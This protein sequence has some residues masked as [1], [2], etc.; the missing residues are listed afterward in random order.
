MTRQRASS[1]NIAGIAP[2]R[3]VPKVSRRLEPST[4]SAQGGR[5]KL[6]L[7]AWALVKRIP[8]V[9]VAMTPFPYFVGATASVLEARTMMDE[10][11]FEHLPVVHD[12]SVIGLISGRDVRVAGELESRLVSSGVAVREV[13]QPDPYIVDFGDRLDNVVAQMAERGVDSALVLHQGKLAG[14]ITA[15]DVCRL[16]A[17]ALRTAAGIPDDDDGDGDAA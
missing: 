15:T 12:G 2:D 11:D 10:H 16:L 14:I 7:V 17:E 4:Q 13:C 8:A 9:G 6:A 5:K 1:S 3:P